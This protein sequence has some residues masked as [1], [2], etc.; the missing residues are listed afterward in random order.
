MVCGGGSPGSAC[1]ACCLLSTDYFQQRHRLP[2]HVAARDGAMIQ[3]RRLPW[4][5]RLCLLRAL[6]R[7]WRAAASFASVRIGAGRWDGLAAATFVAPHALHAARSR[8]GGSGIVCPR[9]TMV[10]GDVMAWR[11]RGLWHSLPCMLPAPDYWRHRH[12]LPPARAGFRGGGTTYSRA[13]CS[14]PG[15][16]GTGRSRHLIVRGDATIGGGDTLGTVPLAA[17]LMRV[18]RLLRKVHRTH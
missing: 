15:G 16:S 2:R 17:R 18:Y 4:R 5:R 12:R 14:R 1:L 13:A 10:R 8:S 7:D 9:H 3:R 11:W 6:D